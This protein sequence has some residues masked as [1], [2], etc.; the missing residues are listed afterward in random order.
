MLCLCGVAPNYAGDGKHMFGM[1][2]ANSLMPAF[3]LDRFQMCPN[4]LSGSIDRGAHI[5]HMHKY[6]LSTVCQAQMNCGP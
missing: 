5:H 6:M 1:K 4:M 2:Y 3:G